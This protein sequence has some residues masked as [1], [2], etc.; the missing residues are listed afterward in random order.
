MAPDTIKPKSDQ[1][2][3]V[4]KKTGGKGIVLLF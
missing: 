2:N 1:E 3:F 4:V